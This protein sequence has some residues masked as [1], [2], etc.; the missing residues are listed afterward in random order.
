[1]LN[2][3]E[4]LSLDQLAF[5][6]TITCND[7]PNKYSKADLINHLNSKLIQRRIN[8]VYGICNIKL[9]DKCKKIILLTNHILLGG[10]I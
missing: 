7:L 3:L 9:N 8:E 1:M 4:R 6:Y 5:I 2:Q 10:R